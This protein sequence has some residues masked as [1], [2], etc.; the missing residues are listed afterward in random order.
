MY[1]QNRIVV[2]CCYL[3][4]Q[5]QQKHHRND[6]NDDLPVLTAAECYADMRIYV[7]MCNYPFILFWLKLKANNCI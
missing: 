3:S 2:C 7:F 1:R 4:I 5:S 6:D